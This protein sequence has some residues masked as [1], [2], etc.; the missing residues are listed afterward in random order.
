MEVELSVAVVVLMICLCIS[1]LAQRCWIMRGR[2]FRE[3]E[4]TNTLE[5]PEIYRESGN[6]S[7]RSVRTLDIYFMKSSVAVLINR[8]DFQ[9]PLH[10]GRREGS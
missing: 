10:R 6:C 7:R 9:L 5:Q 8:D 4:G 1:V 3:T 2:R